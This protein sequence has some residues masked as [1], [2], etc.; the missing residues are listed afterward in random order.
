MTFLEIFIKASFCAVL[1][2][3]I[4]GWFCTFVVFLFDTLFSIDEGKKPLRI[5]FSFCSFLFVFVLGVSIL[6]Y[7]A[8]K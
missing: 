7:F 8:Q 2:L 6:M 3:L 1:I 4:F 5:I